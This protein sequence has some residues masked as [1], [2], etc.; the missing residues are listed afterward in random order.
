MPV[1]G[2]PYGL[3][4]EAARILKE[5]RVPTPATVSDRLRAKKKFHADWAI[6]MDKRL[7]AIDAMEAKALPIIENEIH[8]RELSAQAVENDA[9]AMAKMAEE[10]QRSNSGDPTVTSGQ[11]VNGSGGNGIDKQEQ[12]NG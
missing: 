1:P 9:L 11:S 8:E 5:A 6:G 7:D 4:E 3:V 10:L 12:P 2:R